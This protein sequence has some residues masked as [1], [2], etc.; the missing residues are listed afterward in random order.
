MHSAKFI[1]MMVLATDKPYYHLA[2]AITD[3]LSHSHN[4]SLVLRMKTFRI[5]GR[6]NILSACRFAS[7]FP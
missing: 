3:P 6:V 7:L 5:A 4:A 1:L 2:E